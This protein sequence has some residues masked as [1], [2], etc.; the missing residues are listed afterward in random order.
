LNRERA[1]FFNNKQ[2]ASSK[3]WQDDTEI[4]PSAPLGYEDIV[5]GRQNVYRRGDYQLNF[6]VAGHG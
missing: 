6:V 4:Q 3:T 2:S 1:Y 5:D